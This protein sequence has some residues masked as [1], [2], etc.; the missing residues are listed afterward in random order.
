MLAIYFTR[1]FLGRF[2]AVLLAFTGLLQL[3][4]LLDK[5]SA[6]LERGHGPVDML[7]YIGLHLPLLVGQLVPLSILIAALTAHFSLAQRNEIIALR[8]VGASPWRLLRLLIPAVTVIAVLHVLLMDQVAPR[9]E[10]ALQDWW[11]A[12]PPPAG[13]TEAPKPVWVRSG[14]GIISI[15]RVQ[16]DGRRLDGVTIV[17]RDDQ[18]LATGR[19][20]A[21]TARWTDAGWMLGDVDAVTLVGSGTLK[22]KHLDEMPWPEGPSPANILFVA[23]PTQYQSV[24][25]ILSIMDG[26]WSGTRARAYYE[27]QIQRIFSPLASALVMLLLAQPALHGVRR[28]PGFGS[29]LAIGLGL[30][31]LFLLVQGLLSA[32]AEAGTLPATLAVWTPPLIF[33]CIGGT[34]LLYLEE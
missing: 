27:V 31:L 12:R 11:A 5:A 24:Q 32:L 7:T 6:V 3:L 19:T 30:G 21:R 10:R 28:S 34:I 25:R 14:T 23:R 8:S 22:A 4:D 16:E 29:G 2:L 9:A 26:A 15:E 17:S 20:V 33:A 13:E 1:A 18:G